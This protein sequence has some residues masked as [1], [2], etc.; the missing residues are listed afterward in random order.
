[1]KAWVVERYGEPR[2]VM[3]QADVPV[4]QAGPG[5]IRIKVAAAGL[6][7]PDVLLCRNTYAFSPPFP[8]TPGQEVSGVV[9]AAGEGATTRVGNRVMAVTAFY[10]GR[11]GF[12]AETLALDQAAYSVPD[13]MSDPQ[14]AVFAIPFHTAYTGLVQRAKIKAGD[15]VLVHGGSGGTGSAAILLARALGATVIASAGGDEKVLKC[16]DLGA[17]F[18][19]DHL[20]ESFVDQVL[21]VT[22]GRGADIIYDPVGGSCFEESLNCVASEGRLLAIGFASGDWGQANTAKVL[23]KNCSVLGVFVGAYGPDV[24]QP[25]HQSL[26]DLHRAGKIHSVVDRVVSFEEIPAAL[27]E[28]A[29]RQVQGKLV[30][31]L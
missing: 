10:G 28:L 19:I 2:E 3:Q 15:V 4:P 20:N 12:A 22:E 30:A 18:V 14:A 5:E 27:T 23:M 25:A 31:T 8:F 1:M 21:A 26:L 16:R 11:G 24:M 9:T 17:N 13:D 7:L 29:A 6:G